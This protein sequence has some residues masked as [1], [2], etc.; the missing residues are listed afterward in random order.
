[1]DGTDGDGGGGRDSFGEIG[2]AD[3][4]QNG[5]NTARRLWNEFVIIQGYKT[6]HW[7]KRRCVVLSL[8]MVRYQIKTTP[9]SAR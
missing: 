7:E 3:S 2:V 4:T 9:L 1:M 6:V 8:R 5:Q